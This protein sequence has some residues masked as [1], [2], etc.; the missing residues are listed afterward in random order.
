MKPNSSFT[1]P[2][3]KDYIRKNKL[4]HPQIKLTMNKKDLITGLKKIGHWEEKSKLHPAAK[5][6][7]KKSSKKL[8]TPEAKKLLG[9]DLPKENFGG[10][11]QKS[12]PTK[13]K[14]YPIKRWTANL[15]DSVDKMVSQLED[16][17]WIVSKG[18]KNN[19]QKMIT[20]K[21]KYYDLDSIS[22]I[23]FSVG[24]VENSVLKI[25][26]NYNVKPEY[27]KYDKIEGTEKNEKVKTDPEFKK[28]ATE[29]IVK[30]KFSDKSISL[31]QKGVKIEKPPKEPE[32]F[33]TFLKSFNQTEQ[34]KEAVKKYKNIVKFYVV[35]TKLKDDQLSGIKETIL[36]VREK[37]GSGYV[38]FR[39]AKPGGFMKKSYRIYRRYKPNESSYPNTG[40]PPKPD[41][42]F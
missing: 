35:N 27:K 12:K 15:N 19:L 28:F 4:D 40:T 36:S 14:T 21:F 23:P 41:E 18:Q 25:I 5:K 6:P 7:A 9:G 34:H 42:G 30:N 39:I 33:K 29:T 32:A 38:S 16:G 26:A 13:S 31:K 17:G 10:Q 11:S 3:L 20:K 37:N 1:L 22:S 24:F 8:S 2:Q